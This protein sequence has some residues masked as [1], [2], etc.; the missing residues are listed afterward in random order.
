MSNINNAL[1]QICHRY[2]IK[3]AFY[4]DGACGRLLPH[5]LNW[6]QVILNNDQEYVFVNQNGSRHSLLQITNNHS[7]LTI[8]QFNSNTVNAQAAGLKTRTNRV[9]ILNIIFAFCPLL[10]TSTTRMTFLSFGLGDRQEEKTD[11]TFTQIGLEKKKNTKQDSCISHT[12]PDPAVK[13]SVLCRRV[14]II[15][16]AG[17]PNTKLYSQICF[18]IN[19]EKIPFLFYFEITDSITAPEAARRCA[20]SLLTELGYLQMKHGNGRI[21]SV[22][23]MDPRC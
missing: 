7:Q 13:P 14:T 21:F 11:K 8:Q 2:T 15:M 5:N 6:V 19:K 17:R 1:S 18:C 12:F 10:E 4:K 3:T 9:R 16:V 20:V 22:L 23:I